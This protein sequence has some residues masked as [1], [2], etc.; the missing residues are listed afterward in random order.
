MAK[1]RLKRPSNSNSNVLLE[2][3]RTLKRVTVNL[4]TLMDVVGKMLGASCIEQRVSISAA[5]AMD[6]R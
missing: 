4:Y 6:Y 5:E 2:T 1:Q 3:G